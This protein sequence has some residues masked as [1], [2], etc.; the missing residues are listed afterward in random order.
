M[1]SSY[2]RMCLNVLSF[3]PECQIKVL[4]VLFWIQGPEGERG[5]IGD[6]GERGLHVSIISLFYFRSYDVGERR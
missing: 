2:I 4:F 6:P 1:N 3:F 5:P